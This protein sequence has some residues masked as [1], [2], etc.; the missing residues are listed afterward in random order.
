MRTTT[1]VFL[2]V[3]LVLSGVAVHADDTPN[4][5]TARAALKQKLSEL[6]HPA[7]SSLPNTNLAVATINSVE[8]V[9]NKPGAANS[10]RAT[11]QIATT[12]TIAPDAIFSQKVPAE[13]SSAQA[14]ALAALKE[15]MSQ[16]KHAKVQLPSDTNSAATVAGTPPMAAP[17]R[18]A[19]TAVAPVTE[20]PAAESPDARVP[21]TDST[22][23]VPASAAPAVVTPAP[24]ISSAMA[25]AAVLPRT[26]RGTTFPFSSPGR[27]R[28]AN[29]L[30]TTSGAIYQNVEVE[31]VVGDG[32]VISFTPAPGNWAMTK[33]PFK[34]LP[35]E[36][37]RQYEK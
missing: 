1:I 7:V 17:L 30:V 18:E 32:I 11:S 8:S 24:K 13:N 19:A 9:T 35:P 21:A 37:R 6:N 5:A 27:A 31:K 22:G 29:E 28:P 15:K 14:V 33:V 2:C 34:D 10:N 23:V 36:I 25:P 26:Q 12:S 3:A 20:L 4:Q 16:L